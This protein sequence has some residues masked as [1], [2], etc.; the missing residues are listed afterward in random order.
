MGNEHAPSAVEHL[1][2]RKAIIAGGR[3]FVA[4][5]MHHDYLR[6][7]YIAPGFNEVICGCAKGADTFGEQWAMKNGLLVTRRPADWNRFGKSAGYRRNKEMAI[8]AAEPEGPDGTGI[9][10]L[11]PG[12]R[13]TAHMHDLALE[14][15][16]TLYAYPSLRPV[17]R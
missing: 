2:I 14:H 17:N 6:A 13:G 11:F 12:G 7:L 16:L 4:D 3:N 1:M 15:G 9:C 5:V 10:I 8:Y